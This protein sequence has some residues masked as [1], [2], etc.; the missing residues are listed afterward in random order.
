ML[1]Y[2]PL[3]AVAIAGIL[4]L[5]GVAFANLDGS[6]TISQ[7]NYGYV[8]Q[9]SN[10]GTVTIS[11]DG[12]HDITFNVS[13]TDPNLWIHGDNNTPIIGFQ[14]ASGTASSAVTINSF[15]GTGTSA[16]SWSTT[17]DAGGQ[18]G[19]FGNFN[20]GG[21]CNGTPPGNRCGVAGDFTVCAHTFCGELNF[22]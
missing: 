16:T 14:I 21:D 10:C 2:P 13:L 8:C 1:K 6:Y 19:G 17:L 15:S 11:G 9:S 18:I 7:T 3:A 12:T 20:A 4:G 22:G 5:P